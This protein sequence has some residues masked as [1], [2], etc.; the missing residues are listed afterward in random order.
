M[1]SMLRS[2]LYGAGLCLLDL[3]YFYGNYMYSFSK[4]IDQSD[5]RILIALL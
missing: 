2:I 1:P 3:D 5:N 4:H